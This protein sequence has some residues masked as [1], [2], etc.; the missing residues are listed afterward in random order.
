MNFS[1]RSF[2][3]IF[4]FPSLPQT[5]ESSNKEKKTRATNNYWKQLSKWKNL[6]LSYLL[7]YWKWTSIFKVIKVSKIPHFFCFLSN[8]MCTFFAFSFSE[9]VVGLWC[10][11]MWCFHYRC[12]C[13][14]IRYSPA[15][16]SEQMF[17]VIF[18]WWHRKSPKL[19]L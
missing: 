4:C 18:S 8:I 5:M 13:L 9:K 19:G 3:L 2:H 15:L 10:L 14:K 6:Q 17:S 12:I 1:S 7:M 11:Q 16:T